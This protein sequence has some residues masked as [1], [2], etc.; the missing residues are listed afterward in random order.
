MGTMGLFN[1]MRADLK[2]AGGPGVTVEQQA[3]AKLLLHLDDLE[4]AKQRR[5]AEEERNERQAL[6]ARTEES[7]QLPMELLDRLYLNRTPAEWETYLTELDKRNEERRK[8]EAAAK[9]LAD[10]EARQATVIGWIVIIAIVVLI[11]IFK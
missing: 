3:A 6:A 2:A 10:K 11:A 7:S 8:K 1:R 4:T 9:E 5:A